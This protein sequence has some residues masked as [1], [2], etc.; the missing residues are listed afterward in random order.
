MTSSTQIGLQQDM[1]AKAIYDQY[2]YFTDIITI[3]IGYLVCLIK[4][5][6][7]FETLFICWDFR[8]CIPVPSI[9]VNHNTSIRAYWLWLLWKFSVPDMSVQYMWSHDGNTTRHYFIHYLSS[10]PAKNE[11]LSYIYALV[12]PKCQ[13]TKH[14]LE[15]RMPPV[16]VIIISMDSTSARNEEPSGT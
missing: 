5:C 11:Y 2:L 8:L 15:M 3:S 10:T 16:T 7:W 1:I 4:L 9:I 6:F 13:C 12:F 14:D